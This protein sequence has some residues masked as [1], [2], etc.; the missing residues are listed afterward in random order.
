V[1]IRYWLGKWIEVVE[2]TTNGITIRAIIHWGPP[3]VL[4]RERYYTIVEER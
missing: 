2:T 4:K 1:T 3:L